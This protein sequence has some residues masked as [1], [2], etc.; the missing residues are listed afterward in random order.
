VHKIGLGI[1]HTIRQGPYWIICFSFFQSWGLTSYIYA[2]K[3][4]CKHRAY[5]RQ[6]YT[7]EE[8]EHLQSLIS[9]AS[10]CNIDFYYAISPGLDIVY[11]NSKEIAGLKRKLDQVRDKVIVGYW[12][13]DMSTISSTI[14]IQTEWR[15]NSMTNGLSTHFSKNK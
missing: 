4:D 10:E 7:V 2:P 1:G 9:M 12:A 14:C 11:S 13:V 3:D 15:Y 6:L 8:A 5:W